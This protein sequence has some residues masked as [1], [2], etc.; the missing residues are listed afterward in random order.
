[1]E[2]PHIRLAHGGPCKYYPTIEEA[3]ATIPQSHLKAVLLD[4]LNGDTIWQDAEACKLAMIDAK[5]T[6]ATVDVERKDQCKT[7]FR[8]ALFH[9]LGVRACD[10]EYNNIIV[11]LGLEGI[12]ILDDFS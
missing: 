1:L 9:L 5:F 2:F 4:Q 8:N 11:A 3:R 6:L 12:K 10:F 7:M